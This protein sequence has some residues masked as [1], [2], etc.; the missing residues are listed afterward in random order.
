MTQF[1]HTKMDE[2]DGFDEAALDALADGFATAFDEGLEKAAAAAGADA[3]L[4]DALPAT[5]GAGAPSSATAALAAAAL[6]GR[7]DT[8]TGSREASVS[9][10]VLVPFPDEMMGPGTGRGPPRAL[11]I[12]F[13][14]YP[15]AVYLNV[16]VVANPAARAGSAF[17]GSGAG[18][19]AGGLLDESEL[20][21]SESSV[22][23]HAPTGVAAAIS[24]N[25][26]VATP[27]PASASS[28]EPAVSLLM[29]EPG[30]DGELLESLA[31]KFCRRLKRMVLLSCNVGVGAA[32][33]AAGGL[34]DGGTA[35][36]AAHMLAIQTAGALLA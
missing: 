35:A 6:S 20:G 2:L 22:R 18:A 11:A 33:S 19:G 10:S 26:V 23:P 15:R 5:G 30:T 36:A 17:L 25:L 27:A 8:A 16:S 12:T 28:S 29:L 21:L 14:N 3:A 1:L 32:A 31:R 13:I 7:A 9:G 4:A 34:D 24:Q